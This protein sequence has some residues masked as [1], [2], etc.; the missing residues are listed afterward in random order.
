MVHYDGFIQQKGRGKMA[1]NRK[2]DETKAEKQERV[3][4]VKVFDSPTAAVP[5]ASR[6]IRTKMDDA[7]LDAWLTRKAERP[8]IFHADVS[9]KVPRSGK[10]ME[11][12]FRDADTKREAKSLIY[13]DVY[14]APEELRAAVLIGAEWSVKRNINHIYQHMIYRAADEGLDIKATKPQSEEWYRICGVNPLF[15][16]NFWT[17]KQRAKFA[18]KAKSS[19]VAGLRRG[20]LSFSK[21]PTGAVS[22]KKNFDEKALVEIAKKS[23]LILWSK[24]ASVKRAGRKGRSSKSRKPKS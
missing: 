6:A 3:V 13:Y 1:L 7:E 15:K 12:V 18:Q 22:S 4:Y 21:T 11:L 16:S 20:T 14:E 9:E 5:I 10:R 19:I 23:P 24:R 17:E 8:F 2:K